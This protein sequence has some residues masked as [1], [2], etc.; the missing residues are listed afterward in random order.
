MEKTKLLA[1]LERIRLLSIAN[2]KR[3]MPRQEAYLQLCSYYRTYRSMGMDKRKARYEAVVM[4]AG[5]TGR[6]P[7]EF[8]I[9]LNPGR[10][11]SAIQNDQLTFF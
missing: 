7:Q 5:M 6:T 4:M 3:D 2:K 10:M 9:W 11:R 8:G 1:Q